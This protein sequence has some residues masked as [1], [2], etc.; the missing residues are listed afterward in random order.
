MKNV[1]L[2]RDGD[3]METNFDV[4]DAQ[5]QTDGT[6]TASLWCTHGAWNAEAVFNECG[7]VDVSFGDDCELT[8]DSYEVVL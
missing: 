6:I 5:K 4:S 1:N 3:G 8:Y 2:F 7:R